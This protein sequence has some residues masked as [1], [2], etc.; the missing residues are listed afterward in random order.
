MGTAGLACRDPS[1]GRGVQ[2][3]VDVTAAGQ[4]RLACVGRVEGCT[5]AT[6]GFVV[7]PC[8]LPPPLPPLSSGVGFPGSVLDPAVP[9]G[10]WSLDGLGV[11]FASAVPDGCA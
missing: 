8:P 1:C 9:V 6:F 5:I 7:W 4:G 2:T 10:L 11:V 3:R